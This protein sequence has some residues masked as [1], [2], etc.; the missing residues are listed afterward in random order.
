MVV[1][2]T[3]MTP[4]QLAGLKLEALPFELPAATT[5]TAPSAIAAFTAFCPAALQP[6]LPPRLRL[7]TR[8]G[9]ALI[10]RPATAPPAAHTI[11]SLMSLS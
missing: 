6:P 10:G 5:T 9:L 7:S 4:M 3:V 8:A 11:A 2:A 1:A